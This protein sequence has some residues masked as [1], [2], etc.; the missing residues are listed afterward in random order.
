MKMRLFAF[1]LLTL[2]VVSCTREPLRESGELEK[3]VGET[4]TISVSISP[5]TRVSYTDSDTLGSGGRLSWQT[6]DTLLL[7]GYDGTTYKGSEKFGYTGTGNTFQGQEVIGATSY[8]AY[9]PGDIITLDADGNVNL[10]AA[11][12]WQQTQ[13]GDNTTAHLRNKLLLFD[14]TANPLNQTFSLTLKSSIIRFDLTNVPQAVG[15]LGEVI[16]TVETAAGVFK[17]MILNVTGVTFSATNSSITAFLAFDPTVTGIA[18]NGKVA[19][20]LCGSKLYQW[21]TTVT[22]QTTYT[23]GNRYKAAVSSGWTELDLPNNPLGYFAEHNMADTTGTFETGHDASGLYLF[24]WDDARR[25]N[26]TP[27]TLNGKSYY[28]PTILEWRAI[29]PYSN[30]SV[31]FSGTGTRTLNNAAVIVGGDNYTMSGTFENIGNV[32][33]ATLTY[34]RQPYPLYAIARYRTENLGAGN[35]D[36]RMVVDMKSTPGAYTIDQAK[37]ADWNSV[38]VVSRVFPAAG[39]RRSN[40]ML[41]LQGMNGRYWASTKGSTGTY[42]WHMRFTGDNAHSGAVIAKVNGFSVRLV[43][44]E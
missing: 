43:S 13:S 30:T 7:A 17:S 24:N 35:A 36:A 6:G 9:Y 37:D 10:L 3:G 40:G 31:N 5:E 22:N 28:L 2:L 16:W 25:Y 34:T 8:K 23:A 39:S 26:T 27:A 11:G 12:F 19:I 32:V 15:E 4:V 1:A 20:T 41:E 14:E 21:S 42:A 44:R 33:Y 18:A 29:I 38:G